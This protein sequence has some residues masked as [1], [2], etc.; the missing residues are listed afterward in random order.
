MFI[1]M[2]F[3]WILRKSIV[4]DSISGGILFQIALVH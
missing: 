1:E 2:V 4:I 3:K